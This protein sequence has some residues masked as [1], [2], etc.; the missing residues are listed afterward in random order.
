M[1]LIS[2]LLLPLKEV[3]CLMVMNSAFVCTGKHYPFLGK[4]SFVDYIF[5]IACY[6]L[7]ILLICHLI[8]YWP[9]KFLL[10]N[11]SLD[12]RN[13][14][15]CNLSLFFKLFF[16]LEFSQYSVLL[17]YS[18]EA[19]STMGALDLW[20]LDVHF[21]PQILEFFNHYYFSLSLFLLEFLHFQFF[22]FIFIFLLCST[23]SVDFL[24]SFFILFVFAF[25]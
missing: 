15:V 2:I 19:Q 24:H 3:I 12:L 5:P 8:L 10:R 9:E 14:L 13:S 23:T 22:I 7:S 4:D 16:T 17:C 6:F 25:L 20:F 18:V 1:V 11:L 21:L